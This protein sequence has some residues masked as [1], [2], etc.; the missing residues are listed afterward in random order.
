MKQMNK[1]NGHKLTGTENRQV[2]VREE[3][4]ERRGISEGD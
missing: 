3:V 2:V 4:V 1:Q